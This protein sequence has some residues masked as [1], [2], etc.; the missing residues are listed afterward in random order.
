MSRVCTYIDSTHYAQPLM[1]IG[2]FPHLCG[3]GGVLTSFAVG[4]S[5]VEPSMPCRFVSRAQGLGFNFAP[6]QL[7]TL[8]LNPNPQLEPRL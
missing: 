4:G 3:S 5:R 7:W 6:M 8:I 1:L 2:P